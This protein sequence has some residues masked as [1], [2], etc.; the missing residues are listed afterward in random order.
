MGRPGHRFFPSSPLQVFA[1]DT[2]AIQLAWGHLPLGDVRAVVDGVE[3][4]QHHVGGPGS[5]I[6]GNLS[7]AT[8]YNVAVSWDRAGHREE[9]T[10]ELS[11][12]TLPELGTRVL[13][14]FATVN[15]LHI[16]AR[17]FGALK[18]MTDFEPDQEPF[19]LRCA[20][21]AIEDAVLW[22]AEYLVIKGDALHA[23][24][25]ENMQVLGNLVDEFSEL[26]MMLLPGNH[27]VDGRGDLDHLQEPVGKRRL[28]YVDDVAVHEI[29]GIQIIGANT[30]IKKKGIGTITSVRQ[31]IFDSVRRDTPSV[32][33]IHH[34]LQQQNVHRYWPPGIPKREAAEFLT[35]LEQ[36]SPDCLVTC[37]HTHRNRR[38]QHGKIPIAEVASTRDWPGVWAGYTVFEEGVVQTVRRASAPAAMRWHEYGRQ[39]VG[40]LW[41]L[42]SP[43]KLEDRCFAHRWP[44]SAG[45]RS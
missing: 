16:G 24:S 41:S 34:Q 5:L 22:G 45:A 29:A 28:H 3:F 18:T 17:R 39:A 10:A 33:M 44:S 2:T 38:H 13:G 8:T 4:E 6:L 12:S 9:G 42:W 7:P 14:K 1:V 30:T 37:G 15:D 35:A 25:T 19:A 20:R 36:R 27:D 21:S 43:G 26:P 23:Q 31:P 40:G 32:V 11:A